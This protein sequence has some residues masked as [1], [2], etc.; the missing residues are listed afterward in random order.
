MQKSS[1]ISLIPTR[2]LASSAGSPLAK[3]PGALLEP[4]QKFPIPSNFGFSSW[5]LR[6]SHSPSSHG[7]TQVPC[8]HH[9]PAAQLTRCQVLAATYST[10]HLHRGLPSTEVFYPDQR[11]PLQY[12]STANLPRKAAASSPPLLLSWMIFNAAPTCQASSGSVSAI[13]KD[14]E[15]MHRGRSHWVVQKGRRVRR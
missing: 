7:D 15:E 10:N 9:H 11:A 2:L 3:P 4:F 14:L 6:G 1:C 5:A 13:T 12:S 8:V